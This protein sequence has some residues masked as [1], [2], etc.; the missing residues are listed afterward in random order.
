MSRDS[1]SINNLNFLSKLKSKKD[2]QKY[3]MNTFAGTIKHED[4]QFDSSKSSSVLIMNEIDGRNEEYSVRK[5]LARVQK[6]C[7]WPPPVNDPEVRPY[8]GGCT[9]AAYEAARYDY[10]MK[11][12]ETSGKRKYSGKC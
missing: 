4:F 11:K 5:Y 10:I 6:R 3:V 12:R 7:S 9:T 8:V 1:F 2:E